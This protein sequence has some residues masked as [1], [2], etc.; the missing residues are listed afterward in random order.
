MSLLIA[1]AGCKNAGSGGNLQISGTISN[2]ANMQVYLDQVGLGPNSANLV[3]A[4]ADANGNGEFNMQL[5]EPLQEGIYRLRIGEQQ[6]ALVLDG[7]EEEIKVNGDLVSLNTFQYELT[8]SPSSL[9]YRNVM[10]RLVSRSMNVEDLRS[11]V[12]TVSNPL[13]GVFVSMQAI[14][15]NTNL[16]DIYQKAEK[17]LA[18]K[19]PGNS[20]LG[21]FQSFIALVQR[22]AAAPA[23]GGNGYQFIETAQRQVAPDIKLPSPSGKE[24]AL[25]DLKGKVVLLDFWASWCR[26]CR[27]ENPNVVKIYNK[28]KEQGFTVFSV[29]LDGVDSRQMAALQNDAAKIQEVLSM[30]KK[31]WKDAIEKDGLIWE[32]HVSDLKKWECAP[33]NLYGVN[34]IPRTFMIDK[35]GKIAAV[36]LRGAEQIEETLQKL[37]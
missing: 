22:S 13:T 24:Y 6:V 34:S 15:M 23:G 33:A 21:E 9:G 37:L 7:T 16:M 36:N 30:Q 28:Y 32:Y 25:S 14:G 31:L 27:M 17:R 8:G 19:S 20:Y 3:K 10:Q 26:P 35:E 4:K 1:A 18:E 12:D 5:Q 11:F 2:A 29:S